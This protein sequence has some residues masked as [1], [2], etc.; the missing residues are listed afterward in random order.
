M[1][2]TEIRLLYTVFYYKCID[3]H[4]RLFFFNKETDGNTNGNK[5][6]NEG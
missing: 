6:Q 4:Y 2:F 5:D 1:A 3:D